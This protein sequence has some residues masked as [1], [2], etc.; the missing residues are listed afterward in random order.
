VR[1][2][3][4]ENILS[5]VDSCSSISILNKC[6][7]IFDTSAM[8]GVKKNPNKERRWNT[9]PAKK[10]KKAAPKKKGGKKKTRR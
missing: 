9:M 5:Y 2:Y 4:L 10:K 8:L 1:S 7:T 3:F 6:K